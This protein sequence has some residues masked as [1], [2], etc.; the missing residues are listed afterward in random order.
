M[1]LERLIA[2]GLVSLSSNEIGQQHNKNENNQGDADRYGNKEAL[3][4][5]A[6]LG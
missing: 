5:R 2:T 1:G 4:E 6:I 3:I